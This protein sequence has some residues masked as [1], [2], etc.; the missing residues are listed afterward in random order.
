MVAAQGTASFSR[1]SDPASGKM[2]AGKGNA[3]NP[4][5]FSPATPDLSKVLEDKVWSYH[6]VAPRDQFALIIDR[7]FHRAGREMQVSIR[8]RALVGRPK[9]LRSRSWTSS[10]G[11]MFDEDE[12]Y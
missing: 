7:M 10:R 1:D 2:T 12:A 3:V 9:Q 5:E 11:R 4:L 6:A 8:V